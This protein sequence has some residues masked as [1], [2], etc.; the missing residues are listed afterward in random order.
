MRRKAAA[1]VVLALCLLGCPQDVSIRLS[2][3]PTVSNLHFVVSNA[4]GSSPRGRVG[5]FLI[6][7]RGPVGQPSEPLLAWDLA[8]PEGSPF[9]SIA[10][11]PFG[12]VPVG[13]EERVPPAPLKAGHSYYAWSGGSGVA[14]RVLPDG[15]VVE[16][17]A[18]APPTAEE[19]LKFEVTGVSDAEILS[20]IALLKNAVAS[21][22]AGRPSEVLRYP[23]RVN[24]SDSTWIIRNP[25]EFERFSP[26]LLPSRLRSEI[27]ELDPDTLF[28]NWQG[29]MLARGAVWLGGVCGFDD[30][31]SCPVGITVINLPG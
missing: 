24:R 8:V 11:I 20:F 21:S 17:H 12:V 10:S 15:T 18:S 22:D 5:A 27:A 1:L 16:G 26:A 3:A 6:H 7:D 4:A 28:A 31:L 19:S 25:D 23:I 2:D 30:A 9:V 29:V 14:F 13:M